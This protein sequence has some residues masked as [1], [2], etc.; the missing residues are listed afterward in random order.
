MEESGADLTLQA[1]VADLRG[2]GLVRRGGLLNGLAL[3]HLEELLRAR[4]EA[5][6]LLREAHELRVR[7]RER[8]HLA[9]PSTQRSD[10]HLSKRQIRMLHNVTHVFACCVT[11]ALS[12]TVYKESSENGTIVKTFIVP[13]Y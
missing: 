10:P 6:A 2:A 7:G 5:L 4:A 13:S 9:R 1:R 3:L 11:S 12:N 8:E